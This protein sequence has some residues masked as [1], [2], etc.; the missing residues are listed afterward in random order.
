MF[1]FAIWERDSGRVVLAR[2]RLGIKPLYLAETPG[3][4]CASP[5]PCRRC[6]PAAAIDTDIDPVALHHYMSFHAVVPAPTTILQGVRKLPPGHAADHRT[7]WHAA[8][9][10][11]LGRSNSAR[12]EVIESLSRVGLAGAGAADAAE[13]GQAAAGGRR[14]GGR[15]AV[16]RPRLQLDHRACWP[17]RAARPEDVLDRLRDGRRRARRRVPVFRHHRQAVRHRPPQAVRR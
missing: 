17:S 2:D 15:A 16:G 4:V 13:G 11:L 6:S 10:G 3:M 12:S 8:R 14:A 7:R 1:A 5:P 9:G